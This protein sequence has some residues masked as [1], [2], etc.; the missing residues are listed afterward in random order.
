MSDSIRKATVIYALVLRVLCDWFLICLMMICL[1]ICQN[2][3]SYEMNWMLAV[4]KLTEA[5][6]SLLHQGKDFNDKDIIFQYEDKIILS[7]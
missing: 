4:D 7:Q 5:E 6:L 2:M 3:R 1:S